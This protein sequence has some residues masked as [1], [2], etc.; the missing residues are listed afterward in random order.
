MNFNKQFEESINEI[1]RIHW[2]LFSIDSMKGVSVNTKEGLFLYYL[3][4]FVVKKHKE[5]LVEIG[6]YKGKSTIYIAKAA[7]KHTGAKNKVYAVDPFDGG[8]LPQYNVRVKKTPSQK[9][10]PESG[11]TWSIFRKNVINSQVSYLIHLIKKHLKMQ[12][13]NSNNLF[14]FYLLMVRTNIKM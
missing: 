3:T 7:V 6:S 2:M 14:H 12:S 8:D 10:F 1:E 11:S 9:D 13:G 4:K 5:P